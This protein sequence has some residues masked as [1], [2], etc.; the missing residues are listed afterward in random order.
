M[1]KLDEV[2]AEALRRTLDEATDAKAAKRLMVGLAYKQG[3]RVETLAEWYGIPRST[4]YSWL[5]RF[6]ERP[7]DEAIEDEHR[8][9]RPPKLAPG[10][11]ADLERTLRRAPGAFGFEGSSWTPALLQ[12]YVEQRFG[13]EYSLGHARRLLREIRNDD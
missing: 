6:E 3:V 2:D 1:N 10:Q 13:V 8:P 5:D 4:V 7:I 12:E 9:G 11:R